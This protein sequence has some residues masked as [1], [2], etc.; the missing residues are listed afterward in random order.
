MRT[1]VPAVGHTG[2]PSFGWRRSRRRFGAC[3]SSPPSSRTPRSSCRAPPA[4]RTCSSGCARRPSTAVAEVVD[5]RRRDGR[6]RGARSGPARAARDGPAVARRPPGCPTSC[7]G[8]P[9]D[10]VTLPGT[11]RTSASVPS[12]VGLHLLARARRRTG[13]AGR[14]GDRAAEPRGAR[15]P[16]ARARATTGRPV[17]SSSARAADGTAPTPRSPTTRERPTTTRAC[18]P[19]SPTPGPAAR[20]RLAADDAGPRRRAGGP[21]LGAVAGAPRRG[22]RPPGPVAAAG[23][24]D[25]SS[26]RSTRCR[27]SGTPGRVSR[28]PSPTPRG[29]DVIRRARAH[30][31]AAPDDRAGRRAARRARVDL[32]HRQGRRPGG[33]LG[34]SPVLVHHPGPRRRSTCRSVAAGRA[35]SP[36]PSSAT[37]SWART[38][39]PRRWSGPRSSCGSRPSRSPST[40]STRSTTSTASPTSSSTCT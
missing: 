12:A 1:T 35:R 28:C 36:A 3:S 17:W 33:P 37:C 5:G 6:R 8:G 4:R 7:S 16:R 13:R 19:T 39:G 34:R 40:P 22:G 27:S 11:V 20:A 14:R 15:G 26:E 23:G 25:A 2:V 31:P 21:G 30:H 10:P 9:P 32:R 24:V 38:R 29:P 18:W